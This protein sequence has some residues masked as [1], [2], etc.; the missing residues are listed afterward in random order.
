MH[1]TLSTLLGIAFLAGAVPA[2]DAQTARQARQEVEASMLVTG[3][4][5][6]DRNGQVTALELDQRDKLPPYVIDMLERGAPS[7]RFEPILV[8][9][10]PALAR[11]KMSV[12]LVMTPGEGS[13]MHL[14]IAS[15]H[16]GEQS[17][18]ND[19]SVTRSDKL[20]PPRYPPEVA[21]MGGQGT[22]YLLVKV[23]RDG[24]TQDVHAEQ[25]NLTA[26]GNA[27]QMD[28]IR[29]E[30]TKA[31]VNQARREWTWTPPTTGEQADRDYWV[32][33]IPV[34][35]DLHDSLKAPS[36]R[37]GQ[38]VGY[39]PGERSQPDWSAPTPPGFRP[40]ALVAGDSTPE[41]SRFRLLTPFEG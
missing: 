32:V 16:F 28:R 29:T 5:D 7:L 12:R 14:R 1:R 2:V 31:A 22:V 24:S 37:Y 41:I 15:A 39:H 25:V 36:P 8:E 33:R 17:S 11:A 38:W 35:F 27:R 20:P 3:H 19:T 6:I 34:S 23:A 18:T 13:D 21:R 9:G 26:L 40:D 30:L 10:E 4:V